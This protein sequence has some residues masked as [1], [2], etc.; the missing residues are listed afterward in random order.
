LC[1][2][3]GKKVGVGGM[4]GG[5]VLGGGNDGGKIGG[6]GLGAGGMPSRAAVLVRRAGLGRFATPAVV[7]SVTTR[8]RHSEAEPAKGRQGFFLSATQL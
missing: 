5:M 2:G 4:S 7:V 8:S 3:M 1:S 6:N